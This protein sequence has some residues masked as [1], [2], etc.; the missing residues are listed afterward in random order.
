MWINFHKNIERINSMR[1]NLEETMSKEE[2]MGDTYRSLILDKAEESTAFLL[3]LEKN[4]RALID[5]ITGRPDLQMPASWEDALDV[6]REVPLAMTAIKFLLKHQFSHAV[7]ANVLTMH[8]ENIGMLSLGCLHQRDAYFIPPN[9]M[10]WRI[11]W[12]NNDALWADSTCVL[13]AEMLA[14]TKRNFPEFKG[15]LTYASF[16]YDKHGAF[17][18]MHSINERSSSYVGVSEFHDAADRRP[19]A[20]LIK[21][22]LIMELYDDGEREFQTEFE[23]WCTAMGA[24]SKFEDAIRRAPSE[25]EAFYVTITPSDYQTALMLRLS[26]K[27]MLLAKFLHWVQGWRFLDQYETSIS[28]KQFF[29]RNGNPSEEVTA[30]VVQYGLV[31]L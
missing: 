27:D 19:I 22:A 24:T 6:Y 29:D 20:I 13:V 7:F 16:E 2:F 15:S 5:S 25:P 14:T 9:S 28:E 31:E 30:H 26:P 23:H 12:G 3:Q 11:S 17:A 8:D 4:V 18:S 10:E 21:K 1:I